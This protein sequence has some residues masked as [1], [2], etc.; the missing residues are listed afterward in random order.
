MVGKILFVGRFGLYG[1][2]DYELDDL[3]K[4]IWVI[5]CGLG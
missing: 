3:R 4:F 1:V 5:F 2:L